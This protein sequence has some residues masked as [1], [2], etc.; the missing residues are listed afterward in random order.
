MFKTKT[1]FAAVTIALGLGIAGAQAAPAIIN[2]NLGPF[3]G[4]NTGDGIVTATNLDWAQTSFIAQGGNTAIANWIGTG[5]VCPGG[6]CSFDVLTHAVLGSFQ[7]PGGVDLNTP[8]LNQTYEVTMVA[9]FTETVVSVSPDLVRF[10]L[11]PTPTTVEFYYDV[12]GDATGIKS[13]PLTGAGFNDGRLVLRGTAIQTSVG[14]FT[15]TDTTAV[16][17]DQ[18]TDDGNNY[19]TQQTTTGIG[20][21]QTILLG[22]IA[23]DFAFFTNQLN[24]FGLNFAN[25]SQQTPFINVNPSSCFTQDFLGTAIASS[26]NTYACGPG[27]HQP[28]QPYSGQG[29]VLDANGYIPVTG[30]V[31]GVI[32][33]ESPD[34]VAQTDFNS[35]LTAIPEPAS[36]ALVGLGLGLLGLGARRR[37]PS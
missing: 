6:N 21:Q 14:I 1:M 28:N 9:K 37:R 26:N 15:I 10:A 12:L 5:G 7:N 8:N 24:N 13:N 3:P 20:T 29:P 18:S 33:P 4:L 27:S 36:L 19:G 34:F 23:Q 30:A 22:G 25:I 17:F 31:N 11:N 35:G 32:N 16:T 2:T